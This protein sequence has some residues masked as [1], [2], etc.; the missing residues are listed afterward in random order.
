VSKKDIDELT[1]LNF[2][3]SKQLIWT[4]VG[5][6]AI[7]QVVF[8][9]VKPSTEVQWQILGWVLSTN[10]AAVLLAIIGNIE[11]EK[12]R[13]LSQKIYTAEMIETIGLFTTLKLAI[14]ESSSEDYEEDLKEVAPYL[15]KILRRYTTQKAKLEKL[16]EIESD[17]V[18]MSA[19]EEVIQ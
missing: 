13:N 11:V 16:A 1:S 6:F 2:I 10:I 8:L 19:M 5:L 7:M 14:D 4:V 9:V 3:T 15:I 18:F 12:A 17:E